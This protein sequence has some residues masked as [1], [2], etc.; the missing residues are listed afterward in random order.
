MRD[1]KLSDGFP[2]IL[3]SLSNPPSSGAD[4]TQSPRND[5]LS[6]GV[7]LGRR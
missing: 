7:A 2:T 1:Q 4:R 6:A 5:D 3:V